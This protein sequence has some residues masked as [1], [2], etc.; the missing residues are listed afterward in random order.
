[1]FGPKRAVAWRVLDAQYFGVAQRR[2]HV[3]VVASARDGFDPAAVLFEFDG[4]RRDSA[5]RREAGQDTAGTLAS[6]TDGSVFPGTDEAC[7]GYVQPI[8]FGGNNQSGPIDIAT[9][10]NACSSGSGRL[11]FETETFLVQPA[12]HAFDARQ[13]DVIQCGD[14]TGP[15][16]TDGHTIGVMTP[17]LAFSCKDYG[18]DAA[19]ELAPTMRAMGHSGSHAN[20]GGQLAVCVTGDFTHTLKAEGFD[21]SEDGTGRGQPIVAATLDAAVGRSRGAGTPVGMLANYG[22]AVRRLTPVECARLQGFRDHYLDIVVRGKPAADGPK[23]KALGNS[24]A[25]T[26]V[27]WLGRR[28]DRALRVSTGSIYKPQ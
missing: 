11:D 13:S 8:A 1:V 25:V 9:A 5:P 14:I 26:N 3:F 7:S 27:H 17:A 6:R 18:A 4:M 28:I 12:P 21:A 2:R 10:R 16:D 20:A 15:L 22:M 19:L 23:Y 24:W